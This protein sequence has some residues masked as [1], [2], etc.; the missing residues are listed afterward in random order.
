MNCCPGIWKA[1]YL[2]RSRTPSSESSYWTYFFVLN[3]LFSRKNNKACKFPWIVWRKDWY[4]S[5]EPRDLQLSPARPSVNTRQRI[6]ME[7][8]VL[9]QVRE[10]SN[11]DSKWNQQIPEGGWSGHRLNIL[12]FMIER[13]TSTGEISQGFLAKNNMK[14]TFLS[15]PVRNFSPPVTFLALKMEGLHSYS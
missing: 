15:Q 14:P 10:M 1:T 11:Q 12:S 7:V 6:V 3:W 5:V 13:A 8:C 2:K 9:W 4:C